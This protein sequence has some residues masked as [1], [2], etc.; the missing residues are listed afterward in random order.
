MLPLT[1][2]PSKFS[3]SYGGYL[4]GGVC[5]DKCKYKFNGEGIVG[6]NI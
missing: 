5:V 6:K 3:Y 4:Y 1:D 2:F